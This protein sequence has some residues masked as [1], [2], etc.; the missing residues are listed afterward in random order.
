VVKY[1]E[2]TDP[3]VGMLLMVVVVA[4]CTVAAVVPATPLNFLAGVLFGVLPGIECKP[5][6]QQM[7]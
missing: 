2:A 7:P 1:I 4:A 6:H 5:Y 3:N